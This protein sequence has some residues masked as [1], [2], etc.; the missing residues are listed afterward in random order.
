MDADT[1]NRPGKMAKSVSR[2]AKEG[3]WGWVVVT[4]GFFY[5]M[6]QSMMTNSGSIL[7]LNLRDK[8]HSHSTSELAGTLSVFTGAKYLCGEFKN[9]ILDD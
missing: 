7:Y 5:I 8:F 1:S 6:L 4:A 9:H 2:K 3:R